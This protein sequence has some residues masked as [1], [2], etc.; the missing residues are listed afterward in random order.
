[1]PGVGNYTAAAIASIAFGESV[2]VV[3]GNVE[4]VFCRLLDLRIEPGQT[5]LKKLCFE[6]GSL[7]IPPDAPGDFNQALM[8]LGQTVCTKQ[9][10]S[11]QQCPVQSVCLAYRRNSQSEA[12]QT[13]KRV[14]PESIHGILL[15]PKYLG[16]FGLI[17]RPQEARFLR[18]TLGFLTGYYGPDL[19]VS[20]DGYEIPMKKTKLIAI[21]KFKHT[22]MNF[23]INMDVYRFEP[24]KTERKRFT[25]YESEE[26]ESLLV[27]NFDRKA[28]HLVARTEQEQPHTIQ[29]AKRASAKEYGLQ[30]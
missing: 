19:S 15:I 8:E 9:S 25:W 1:L 30:T 20:W 11:C 21:G 12:P 16:K 6:L 7:L 4:R 26:I 13:K 24:D 18:E 29:R 3:D 2:P 17:K 23:R 14:A 10:P 5:K 27:A 22:I 28:W